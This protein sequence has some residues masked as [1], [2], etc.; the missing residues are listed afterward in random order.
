MAPDDAPLPE[1]PGLYRFGGDGGE[2]TFA[3]DAPGDRLAIV[4]VRDSI[5][6]ED[7]LW[8]G[9]TFME[10]LHNVPLYRSTR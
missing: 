8:Q 10:F 4:M 3:F 1:L 9:D 2:E 6:D 5:D 7:I